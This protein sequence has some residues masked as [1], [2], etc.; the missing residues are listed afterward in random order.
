MKILLLVPPSKNKV[1]VVRD[2]LYGCWCKGKRIG[3][4]SLPP[5][6]LLQISA[7][8][9][10]DD[11]D[12]QMLDAAALGMSIQVLCSEIENYDTVI[13]STSAMTWEDDLFVLS[14]L[15]KVHVSLKVILFGYYATCNA[16]Y[17]LSFPVVDVIVRHEPER[18][19]RDLIQTFEEDSLWRKIKGIS[20]NLNDKYIENPPYPFIENL[21]ELPFPDRTILSKQASYF[22][23]V[24]KKMPYTLMVTS[25][26]CYGSCIFCTSPIFYGTKIRYRS[27][28]SVIKELRLIKKMGYNE[29]FF[30]D[31]LFTFSQKRTYAICTQIIKEKLGIKWICSTRADLLNRDLMNIMK[32]A[33]CHM[34]RIGVES[35]NQRLLDTA[36]KG[37]DL[38]KVTSVFKWAKQLKIDTHAHLIVGIP[39]ENVGTI[40]KSMHFIR[41]IDPTI[42]TYGVLIPYKGT[43]LFQN[44]FNNNNQAN[45]AIQNNAPESVLS[46]YLTDFSLAALQKYVRKCYL[47]FYL[48]PGYLL[49][50]LMHCSSL[51][52][53]NRIIFA[54]KN[55]IGFIFSKEA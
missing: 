26:G 22:N 24:A 10:Q 29:V 37:V 15:K 11:C 14:S 23:P 4:T 39:G 34:L 36:K 55:V 33:G 25:R 46:E 43:E 47:N 27:V 31:E 35:G 28:E 6:S 54:A 50:R 30:R 48:R 8:L 18:I 13:L 5:L 44:L 40:K 41:K 2:L 32:L 38:E 17:L 51:A 3:G 1:N 19:I 9:K 45:I 42:V 7:V 20:F 53:F 21:D 52:E 49:K 12:V 16:E